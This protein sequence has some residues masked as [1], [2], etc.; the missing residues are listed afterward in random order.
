MTNPTTDDELEEFNQILQKGVSDGLYEV[1]EE[2]DEPYASK[3][4]LT[5]YGNIEAQRTIASRGLPFLVMVSSK[6]ALK[7]GK[8]RTVKS[9]ADEILRDLPNKLKR[10][11]KKNFAPFWNEY[12]SYTAQEYLDAYIEVEP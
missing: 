4:K 8:N 9:M 7:E 10:E 1:A 11:A 5:T 3:Y 2:N 6:L 12:A